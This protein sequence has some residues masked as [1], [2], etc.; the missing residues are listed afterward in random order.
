MENVIDRLDDYFVDSPVVTE[1]NAGDYVAKL[2]NKV[3][4]LELDNEDLK[5]TIADLTDGS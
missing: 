1:E 5:E 3:S 4:I 2:I